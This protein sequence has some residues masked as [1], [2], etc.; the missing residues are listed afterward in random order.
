PFDN[1]YSLISVLDPDSVEIGII[2]DVGVFGDEAG[3]IKDEINRKYYICEL[4]SVKS[5]K[6][7]WGS[8]TWKATDATGDIT[9]TVK[10]TYNNVHKCRDGKILV[11]DSDENRYVLDPVEKL[12]RTTRR[13][14]ELYLI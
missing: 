12:D 10:A 14:I 5:I 7:R 11:I 13:L 9:F 6:E 4:K 3:I 2:E 8:S 1:P